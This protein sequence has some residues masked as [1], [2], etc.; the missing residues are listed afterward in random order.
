MASWRDYGPVCLVRV[1][2]LFAEFFGLVE[3]DLSAFGLRSWNADA[4]SMPTS[5][6]TAVFTSATSSDKIVAPSCFWCSAQSHTVLPLGRW[7][8]THHSTMKLSTCPT[9]R[10]AAELWWEHCRILTGSKTSITTGKEL[11]F[12][13]N[14][15]NTT[16][17]ILSTLWNAKCK[18]IANYA[19]KVV[20]TYFHRCKVH[21]SISSIFHSS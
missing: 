19:R 6:E 17:H 10:L 18:I 1:P 8:L 12:Q 15:Y 5:C 9:L 2:D 13:Q 14:C 3:W 4:M 20:K 21:L 11:N 16:T 7:H